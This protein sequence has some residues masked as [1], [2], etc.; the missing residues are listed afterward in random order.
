M[1]MALSLIDRRGK[2]R[3]ETC[4]GVL[5]LVRRRFRFA[6]IIYYHKTKVA[7]SAMFAKAFGL[8]DD[9]PEVRDSRQRTVDLA[10]IDQI[11]DELKELP[12]SDFGAVRDQFLPSALL[13][14]E[15]GDESLNL[16]LQHRA[17]RQIR[18]AHSDQSRWEEM[19]PPLR[20]IALL[21]AIVRRQL[22]KVFLTFDYSLFTK[23]WPNATSDISAT[24]AGAEKLL[25]T[26]RDT[27]LKSRDNIERQVAQAVGWPD[28]A[29]LLYV[30]PRK[31]Q[32]KGIETYA[33]DA[34]GVVTL[35]RHSL[36]ES[37]VRELNAD[38]S[39]LWR[40]IVL[41]HPKYINEDRLLSDV[42]DEVVRAVFGNPAIQVDREMS[43]ACWFRY[44]P[45]HHRDAADQFRDL[46]HGS[47]ARTPSPVDWSSFND[48]L[49]SIQ[50][51]STIDST[52]HANRAALLSLMRLKRIPEPVSSIRER[53][54]QPGSLS[55]DVLTT[56][57]TSETYLKSRT[58]LNESDVAVADRRAAL[59]TIAARFA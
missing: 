9:V 33:F 51:N 24:A 11:V 27:Q 15:I 53:Y 29:I 1:R 36:V 34:Q 6:E 52:D 43:E 32:A 2:N 21:Q 50:V 58:A 30:P 26:L 16:F 49:E 54:P 3:F 42:A 20:A 41:V 18:R 38:Y 25:D 28:D 59:E 47:S 57:T 48:C 31:V 8:V 7:A 46:M 19:R 39:S 45:R 13:D 44:I 10:G 40:M 22:Y 35:G 12:H 5:D 56:L 37:K 14:P 55:A 4:T 17:W 23:L